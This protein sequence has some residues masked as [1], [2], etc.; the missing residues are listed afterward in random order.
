M[1]LRNPIRPTAFNQFARDQSE[2]SGMQGKPCYS[3]VARR[4]GCR[5]EHISELE[6]AADTMGMF[7]VAL[8]AG[9]TMDA[10]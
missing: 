7:G 3:A 4:A 2:L 9:H 5:S 8:S 6:G 1:Q 10:V